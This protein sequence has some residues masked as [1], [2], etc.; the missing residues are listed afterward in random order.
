MKSYNTSAKIIFTIVLLVAMS[1][2]YLSAR[3]ELPKAKAG[4]PL[5]LFNHET[6][7][8]YFGSLNI[9]CTLCHKTDD[10]YTREKVNKLGCHHC[11]NNA[12]SPS[13]KAA[14]F[15]C[16]TCHKDITK[17]KPAGHNLNWLSRHQ[18]EAKANKNNCLK[19]H[20]SY[21]CTQCHQQRTSIDNKVH[22][23][24]YKFYHSI[25][26]RA[27]PQKCGRCHQVNF[28]KSCRANN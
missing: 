24:S 18:T 27:N 15:K 4:S 3:A 20:Q 25:D 28:C 14:R 11:H 5:D 16:I 26:A 21:F 12:Q 19:C 6:H 8:E 7:H 2:I 10:S 22:D 9:E 13:K 23:R 1:G 17:V